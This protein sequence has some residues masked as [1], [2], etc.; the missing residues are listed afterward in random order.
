MVNR[1]LDNKLP[2]TLI[3]LKKDIRQIYAQQNSHFETRKNK[4]LSLM[5]VPQGRKQHR[6][7]K[8]FKG[9]C[10]ICGKKGHKSADCWESNKNLNKRPKI[11][12]PST[13]DSTKPKMTCTYCGKDGHTMNVCFKKKRDEKQPSTEAADIAFIAV[14]GDEGNKFHEEL[15]LL[16]KEGKD[17]HHNRDKYNISNDTCIIDSGATS[18]MRFSTDGMIN[19]RRW[20]VPVRVG[21]SDIMY[22]KMNGD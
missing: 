17:D 19:L 12:K 11:F 14:D 6:F 7:K 4:E 21:N 13:K 3:N 8:Q 22:S 18:H 15:L 9:D 10:R 1:E 5:S 16:H 20:V 2:I